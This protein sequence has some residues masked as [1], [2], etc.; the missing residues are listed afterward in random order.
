MCV[1]SKKKIISEPSVANSFRSIKINHINLDANFK[2]NVHLDL[3]SNIVD[4]ADTLDLVDSLV[5]VDD[6]DIP[7][8]LQL[9]DD[10]QLTS[11][12]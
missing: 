2:L 5:I 1:T 8:D 4:L 3:K 12:V 11:I 10:N 9:D 6:L 7:D